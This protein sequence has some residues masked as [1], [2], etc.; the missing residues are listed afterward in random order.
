MAPHLHIGHALRI[1]QSVPSTTI[2]SDSLAGYLLRILLFL[3]ENVASYHDDYTEASLSI[4]DAYI[5]GAWLIPPA[6]LD[7]VEAEEYVDKLL[8]RVARLDCMSA[9]E[10]SHRRQRLWEIHG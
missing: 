9:G 4:T 1:C 6:F 3:A 5:D 7:A 2:H 8:K 10:N